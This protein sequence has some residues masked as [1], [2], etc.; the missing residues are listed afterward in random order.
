MTRRWRRDCPQRPLRGGARRDGTG[1][2]RVRRPAP[3]PLPPAAEGDDHR[4]GRCH[5]LH[6]QGGCGADR[7]PRRHP[8]RHGRAR[9]DDGRGARAAPRPLPRGAPHPRAGPRG[10]GGARHR[11]RLHRGCVHACAGAG[12]RAERAPPPLRWHARAPRRPGPGRRRHRRLLRGRGARG[13]GGALA[14]GEDGTR[15]VDAARRD[16]RGGVPRRIRCASR[17]QRGGAPRSCRRRVAGARRRSRRLDELH[18]GQE[19]GLPGARGRDGLA[20]EAQGAPSARIAGLARAPR[21]GHL[22]VRAGGVE[23]GPSPRSTCHRSSP[24]HGTRRSP[25]GSLPSAMG[26]SAPTR[27]ARR[28]SNSRG[29]PEIG[30][31]R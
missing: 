6:A 23:E 24:W 26:G 14:S 19:Q 12:V 9:R 4:P 5:H 8:A 27:C 3:P 31:S 21:R 10:A 28:P 18:H 7:S 16:R 15:R 22:E 25:P 1:G 2:L 20:R 11:T 17:P 13:A 29:W 30:R